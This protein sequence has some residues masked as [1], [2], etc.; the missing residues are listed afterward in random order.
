MSEGPSGRGRARTDTHWWR[1]LY[2]EDG[3][4]IVV[5]ICSYQLM[6]ALLLRREKEGKEEWNPRHTAHTTT[7]DGVAAAAAPG[8]VVVVALGQAAHEP[9]MV[10]LQRLRAAKYQ[11]LLPYRGCCPAAFVLN[12]F[13][14]SVVKITK[15]A[16][17]FSF[18]LSRKPN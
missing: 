1:H 6:K 16:R 8:V 10:S 4:S 12:H 18:L 9:F 13:P 11:A 3:N 7:I 15:K 2:V 5:Y 14:C 17:M